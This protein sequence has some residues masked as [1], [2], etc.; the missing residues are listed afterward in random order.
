M[1][2]L[3]NGLGSKEARTRLRASKALRDAS[4]REPAAVYPY[5]DV[6]AGLLGHPNS[7]IQWNAMRTLANLA[8]A[9]REGR[10]DCLLDAYLA[11]IRGPAMITA[12]HAIQGAAA[13]AAAKPHLA[14]RIAAEIL[15]VE[16]AQYATPECRNVAIGHALEALGK[17]AP[18]VEDTQRLRAFARRQQSNARPATARKAVRLAAATRATGRAASSASASGSRSRFS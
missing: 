10:L 16:K 1:R 9:D 7:I 18:L 14:D 6:F 12:A 17:I 5:L 11:R 15:G 2:D 3:L 4:E 8:P 13:I